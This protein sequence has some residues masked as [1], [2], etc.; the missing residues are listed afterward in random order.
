M[1]NKCTV[2]RRVHR[3]EESIERS[4]SESGKERCRD[5]VKGNKED[6]IIRKN[7]QKELNSIRETIGLLVFT[8]RS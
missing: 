6:R 5:L 7:D 2:H 3:K 4:G 8:L 1:V